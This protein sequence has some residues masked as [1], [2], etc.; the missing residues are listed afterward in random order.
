MAYSAMGGWM[1]SGE[2]IKRGDLQPELQGVRGWLLALSLFLMIAMPLVAVLGIV[3]AW[4]SA[5]ASPVLR[6]ALVSEIVIELGLAAFAV[7]A[8]FSLYRVRRNAVRIAKAYF[9]TM[10]AL[11]AFGL[12]VIL[13]GALALPEGADTG[14]FARLQRPVGFAAI[15]QIVVSAVCLAYLSRSKRVRATYSRQ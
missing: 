4:Q 3:G 14:S 7:H 6:T 13:L 8:G 5:A 10:L 12:I 15:R 1:S 9:I 2:T 11:S